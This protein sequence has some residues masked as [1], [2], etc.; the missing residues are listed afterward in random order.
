MHTCLKARSDYGLCIFPANG[1]QSASKK[2]RRN[3][4][5]LH[6]DKAL[7]AGLWQGHYDMQIRQLFAFTRTWLVIFIE[8]KEQNA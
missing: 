2:S 8:R 5:R 4:M 6:N 7:E 3:I 1:H